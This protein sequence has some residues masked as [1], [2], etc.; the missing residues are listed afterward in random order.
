MLYK[1]VLLKL[2]DKPAINARDRIDK[3]PWANANGAIVA[4]GIT[5]LSI[6]VS[7]T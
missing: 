4:N 7:P 6:K 2:I 3:G 1:P 5:N